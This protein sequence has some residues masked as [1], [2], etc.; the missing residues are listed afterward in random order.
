MNAALDTVLSRAVDSATH[1]EI[2]RYVQKTYD[3]VPQELLMDNKAQPSAIYLEVSAIQKPILAFVGS[4]SSGKTFLVKYLTKTTFLASDIQATTATITVVRHVS[5]QPKEW[6]PDHR[7]FAFRKDTDPRSLD[8]KSIA[9]SGTYEDLKRLTT[10]S[11]SSHHDVVVVF[12]D[13]DQLLD[14]I[15]F[16]CPG[17]GTMKEASQE[18]DGPNFEQKIAIRERVLQA[19]AMRSADGFVVLGAVDGATGVFEDNNTAHVLGELAS[20]AQRFPSRAIHDNVLLVASHANPNKDHLSDQAAVIEKVRKNILKQYEHLPTSLRANIDPHALSNRIVLFYQLDEKEV[21]TKV[22]SIVRTLKRVKPYAS[23]EEIKHEA[24]AQFAEERS[25]SERTRTFDAAFTTMVNEMHLRMDDWRLK[26]A[27]VRVEASIKYFEEKR[28]VALLKAH[29][30][31]EMHA[32]SDK[33]RDERAVRE[34]AWTKVS[35]TPQE[36]CSQAQTRAIQAFQEAYAWFTDADHVEQFINSRY[37]SDQ[38]DPARIHLPGMI[39]RDLGEKFQNILVSEISK[40]E[41]DTLSDLQQFDLS[42]LKRTEG[43]IVPDHLKHLKSQADSPLGL[44]RFNTFSAM[45]TFT[46]LTAGVAGGTMVMAGLGSTLAQLALAK[47]LVLGIGAA[48]AVGLGSAATGLILGIPVAGWV[49][50]GILALGAAAFAI[51]RSWQRKMATSIAKSVKKNKEV[52]VAAARD[53]ISKTMRAAQAALDETLA[54]TKALV[55]AHVAEVHAIA[56]GLVTSDDLKS[57]ATFYDQ[58]VKVL[59]ETQQ[60]LKY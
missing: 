35:R 39:E 2:P 57:A 10:Y 55:D 37:D 19:T 45:S 54:S 1:I 33:Y 9:D 29:Q 56:K 30:S 17:V 36:R 12:L 3:Q 8:I 40:V 41:K 46:A 51:F 15:I 23:L 42:F 7:V 21:T 22:S 48:S 16:D 14:K 13:N 50:G 5:D 24:N 18:G 32:Q 49:I 53:I 60:N 47:V 38:K 44:G 6:K 43:G 26:H 34:S 58:H 25:D 4:Y 20:H 52:A 31:A 27:Q 28:D 11:G 59:R